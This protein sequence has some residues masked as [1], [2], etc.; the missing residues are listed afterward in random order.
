MTPVQQQPTRTT[1]AAGTTLAVEAGA[2][3]IGLV[4]AAA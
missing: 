4:K 3:V 2:S 1:Y